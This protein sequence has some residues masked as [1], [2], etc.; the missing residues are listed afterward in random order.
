MNTQF[1][2]GQKLSLG[3]NLLVIQVSE[4]AIMLVFNESSSLTLTTAEKNTIMQNYLHTIKQNLDV[5]LPALE[6]KAS[7]L[8]T[9][10]NS[11]NGTYILDLVLSYENLMIVYDAT[12]RNFYEIFHWLSKLPVLSKKEKGQKEHNIKVSYGI[13]KSN[14]PNDIHKVCEHTKLSVEQI[15]SLHSNTL[16]NVYAVGF[17]PNF[18]YLGELPKTLHVPR[19]SQPRVQVPA[20]AVAIADHQ[21][22][23]YPSQSP[24]GWH[25]IGYTNFDFSHAKNVIEVGDKVRFVASEQLTLAQD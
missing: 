7:S 1:N 17:M 24:G 13:E 5:D 22:A 12:Q 14:F 15:I 6:R 19:M 10:Q 11:S 25:I 3:T 8:S 9:E 2:A 4:S 16:Y 20:G 21:T 23:V 18:A